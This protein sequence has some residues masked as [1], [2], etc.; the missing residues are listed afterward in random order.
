[1]LERVWNIAKSSQAADEIYIA[2]DHEKI[3]SHAGDFGAKVLLTSEDCKTGSDRVAQALSNIAEDQDIVFNLQG[4]AV[5]TPPWVIKHIIS[6]MKAD[7]TIAIGTCAVKLAGNTLAEF[8]HHKKSNPS[9]GTTVT[10]D[11][12]GNALY[13]S[14]QVLPFYRNTSSNNIVYRHIGL[15]GYQYKYLKL[16]N[17][18]P[19]S[20]LEQ[21][22]Q[23]EQLR[24][25]ENN[26]PIRVL[27][28]DYQ[29]RTHGSVDTSDDVTLVESIIKSEG[30]LIA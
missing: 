23:L 5:L 17:S 2:T 30:E 24:A 21:A 10:F 27:E 18:L 15:Y 13:F 4:D 12:T 11:K 6:S 8:L 3:A 20:Q 1:M 9:S 7:D 28:V 26:I 16:L 25:L 29:G 22:E 14:K 19:Q